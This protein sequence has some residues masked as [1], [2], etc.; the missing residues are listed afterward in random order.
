MEMTA[1]SDTPAIEDIIANFE[2]LV[3]EI[4]SRLQEFDDGRR[5]PADLIDKLRDAGVFRVL[6]PKAYGGY[7]LRVL[8]GVK[9]LEA[10]S[11]I[12]GSL[13][14]TVMIG[15]ETPQ[16]M[17]LLPAS[18]FEELHG[19]KVQ[20][21]QGGAFLPT[22]EARKVEGGY[23]VTGRWGFASGCQNWTHL[24]GNCVLL[25]ENGERMEGKLPG[26][27]ATRSVVFEASQATIEDSWKTLGM[28]GSGS[29]HFHVDD[30]FV[31]EKL[32]FD[33]FFDKPN[34]PGIS[35]FPLMDWY[36]HIAAVIL[37]AAQGALN[38][39][40]ASAQQ[41]KRVGDAQAAAKRELVQYQVGRATAQLRAARAYL[42]AGCAWIETLTG[43]E[44]KTIIFNQLTTTTAFIAEVAR[45]VT[46]TVWKLSGASAGFEG[47]AIQ[48][49]LRDVLVGGQH[50]A[51]NDAA[52]IQLGARLMGEELVRV[53]QTQAPPVRRPQAA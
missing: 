20:P 38:S 19:A 32:S 34:I 15:I 45:E 12:D 35:P 36:S 5:I 16:I 24:F 28:R 1:K 18:T 37:G 13:G 17:A 26:T 27:P 53:P 30:V 29:H 4:R 51:V 25:D 42:H 11:E 31:P 40:V 50:A 41:H 33:I 43:Q 48:R 23:R 21:L 44:D 22:G 10:V 39:Y 7:G 3:P 52:W 14:W 9:L 49:Y 47:N 6:L 2:A 8:D 46:E